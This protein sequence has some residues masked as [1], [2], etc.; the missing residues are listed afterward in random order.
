MATSSDMRRGALRVSSRA[1]RIPKQE[2]C[3]SRMRLISTRRSSSPGLQHSRALDYFSVDC[4]L[5]GWRYYWQSG[6]A[7]R[8]IARCSAIR[9]NCARR[10]GRAATPGSEYIS[11]ISSFVQHSRQK[12][13]VQ[14]AVC[15][16]CRQLERTSIRME[17]PA[18]AACC[19][20]L[21]VSICRLVHDGI[22]KRRRR[23]CPPCRSSLA[24]ATV[25][26]GNG[27]QWAHFP[28]Y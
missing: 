18:A 1:A 5:F 16:V 9:F 26:H 25:L 11:E 6:T 21:A 22:H 28:A 19:F 8:N 4:S 12:A 2:K 13:S 27:T 24:N 10:L 14:P 20:R 23:V 3:S 17:Y 7:E 15:S